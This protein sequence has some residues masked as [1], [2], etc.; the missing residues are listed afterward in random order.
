MQ[1]QLIYKVYQAQRELERYKGFLPD[2]LHESGLLGKLA[3]H[4]L[5]SPQELD[6]LSTHGIIERTN[7]KP[8]Y[9]L[10]LPVFSR[11]Y[12]VNLVEQLQGLSQEFIDATSS[13]INQIKNKLSNTWEQCGHVVLG[14]LIVDGI[15]HR[16]WVRCSGF[17]QTGSVSVIEVDAPFFTT[18]VIPLQEKAVLTY[19]QTPLIND[20]VIV[21]ERL[22]HK[23]SVLT[24]RSVMKD[25]TVILY[26]AAYANLLSLN[27]LY[28]K[29][30][31][32]KTVVY[33]MTPQI[34]AETVR[35]IQPEMRELANAFTKVIDPLE[36]RTKDLYSQRPRELSAAVYTDYRYGLFAVLSYCIIKQW[37]E[38]GYLTELIQPAGQRWATPVARSS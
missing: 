18:E 15:W 5:L 13:T 27:V 17:R 36:E 6:Y 31:D 24:F 4:E 3:S 2:I 38:Q 37:L 10:K 26:G 8:G 29:R 9:R 23:D 35:S 1:W 22:R 28:I 16:L 32:G 20:H 34:N 21:R 14:Q 30:V 7:D 25:S 12:A 11:G 19:W 33:L